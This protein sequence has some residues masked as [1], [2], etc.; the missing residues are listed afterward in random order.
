MRIPFSAQTKIKRQ[1]K[2]L[3]VVGKG[4][5]ASFI[6]SQELAH[7]KEVEN[8][9]RAAVPTNSRK[10]SAFLPIFGDPLLGWQ[11]LLRQP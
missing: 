10:K 2:C 1:R 5:F 11:R 3:Q 8:R 7:F 4:M 6:I 9:L